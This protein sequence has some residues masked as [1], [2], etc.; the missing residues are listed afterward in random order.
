METQARQDHE[1][2]VETAVNMFRDILNTPHMREVD[3]HFH[4]SVEEVME[5]NYKIDR[6][7]IPTRGE[8]S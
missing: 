6:Y 1:L 7:V 2:R 5:F 4:A 8:N 3:I